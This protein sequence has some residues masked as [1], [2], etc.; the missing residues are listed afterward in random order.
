MDEVSAGAALTFRSSPEHLARVLPHC[1]S[2]AT[3]RQWTAAHPAR[4]QCNVTALLVHTLLGGE[5]LKTEAP[6]GWHF[7]NR[8]DGQR[9]DLTASQFEAPIRYEDVVSSREEA[10]AG[11][12]PERYDALLDAATAV[13]AGSGAEPVVDGS[14]SGTS[15]Q[16]HS[17]S[18][19]V[20]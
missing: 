12:R 13:L 20:G 3:S 16:G 1:W 17:A 5:I 19:P 9:H 8:V 2:P 18:P 11:T 6:G 14:L 7:Y 10:L 4:G 15:R